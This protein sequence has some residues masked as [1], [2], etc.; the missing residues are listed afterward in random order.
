[1]KRLRG[2]K[3]GAYR[4]LD[5]CGRAVFRNPHGNG[6]PP[7]SPKRILLAEF[8]GIGDLVI[9]TAVLDPLKTKW[10]D[11]EIWVLAAPFAVDM[12]G[13]DSR[14][15][16]VIPFRFPWAPGKAKRRFPFWEWRRLGRLCTHLRE[17]S[18]DIA[19][20]RP[21]LPMNLLLKLSGAR[22]TLGFDLPGG[23]FL[24]TKRLPLKQ[25]EGDH[26]SLI[27]QAYLQELGVHPG[28]FL[29]CIVPPPDD[30]KADAVLAQFP[31]SSTMLPLVGI[32][33][34]AM[35]ALHRWPLAHF[36]AVAE[37]LSKT[38]RV[39]WF[40]DGD[41]LVSGQNGNPVVLEVRQ[42]LKTFIQ[43]LAR[44]DAF[45]CND[46]GPMHLAAALGCTVVALFGPELPERFA[47][48]NIFKVLESRGMPCR[49]CRNRCEFGHPA[50][51]ETIPVEDVLD[52]LRQ[53]MPPGGLAEI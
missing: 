48:R 25:G 17:M 32:H 9:L 26:E 35:F 30:V 5:A 20:G 14:V 1:M 37:I 15:A 6:A 27:W 49:P 31:A 52:A 42:D 11:A 13:H 16:G 40:L 53:A 7:L 39:L 44:C 18:F 4:V 12:L 33:P 23:A 45:L 28:T 24:P 34:G 36:Q 50:C 46:T 29:P 38:C 8:Y 47:P 22:Y 2:L 3:A 21:D 19:F 51:L 41:E 43:L 10:P